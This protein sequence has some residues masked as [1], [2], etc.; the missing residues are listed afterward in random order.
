MPEVAQAIADW[1][2]DFDPATLPADVRHEAKRR[3]IDSIGVAFA[4][5]DCPPGRAARTLCQRTQAFP[6]ATAFGAS[7]V[8]S[9]DLAVFHNGV[10]I[11]YLDFNDT[12]LSLEPAHPSDNIAAALAAAELAGSSGDDLLAAIVLGYEIQCRLCDAASLRSR[13]WD[14][15][16]YGAI[17]TALLSG[18]LLGL[19]AAQ[20]RHALALA[21]VP[22]VALRQ[23]RAGEL[24][25]WKGC[26]FANAARN[27]LF[28]ALLAAEGM[29]GPWEVFEGAFGFWK[30]VTG[31][32]ALPPFAG[33]TG[34]DWMIRQTYI[35]FWPVEYHAQSAVDAALQLRAQVNVEAIERIE[36]ASFDAAVDIIGND[37]EKFRPQSRETADHS[38]PYCVAVA[39]LAGTVTPEQFTAPWLS[40]RRVAHLLDRT[41]LQRD[42]LLNAGY[43]EGIPNRL[44]ITEAGGRVVE[45]EVRYPRGH[46]RN[47]MTDA[48]V[49]QKFR[50]A[51]AG[52]P[53]DGRQQTVLDL[54]WTLDTAPTLAQLFAALAVNGMGA[55][56]NVG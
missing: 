13:G 51:T 30:Q 22:N 16:T 29:T 2:A 3:L 37:P 43:P 53:L 32:F 20:L 56:G 24:S 1:V 40:D 4:A 9:P 33:V 21:A 12:Y 54:L 17:S 41:T 11:R 55:H 8:C 48:E 36:I 19:S 42:P 6:G 47:P 46:A 15:V 26:A 50:D 52:T 10:L 27:G 25:M 28:A 44:H 35:K 38:M 34:D 23:T 45:Q 14:H 7:S 39:L 5:Y 31:P 49:E 18:K